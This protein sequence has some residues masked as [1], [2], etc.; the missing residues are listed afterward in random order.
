MLVYFMAIWNILWTFGIFYDHLAHC[1]FIWYILSGFGDMDQ[2]K[3]GNLDYRWHWP[4]GPIYVGISV[5]ISWHLSNMKSIKALK[6]WSGGIAPTLSD[7]GAYGPWDR[8]PL[9]SRVVTL[10]DDIDH[11]TDRSL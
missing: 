6:A 5:D 4:Q 3:S 2:N 10:K 9:A 7:I 8:I 1:V 11:C